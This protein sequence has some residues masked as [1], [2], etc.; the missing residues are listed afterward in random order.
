MTNE[1][2]RANDL[3]LAYLRETAPGQPVT[4]WERLSREEKKTWLSKASAEK[5]GGSKISSRRS[6]FTPASTDQRSKVRGRLCLAHGEECAGPIDPAHLV[7]RALGGDEDPR[8]VVPLCRFHHDAYDNN[9]L[10]LLEFLEPHW[11]TE[12]AYAVELVG[13]LSAINQI[14]G[15][16]YV[17]AK[18]GSR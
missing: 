16:R 13:L 5:V 4:Q 9:N 6:G 11:R 10:S 3:R 12:Q 14:T 15:E 18:E 7:D 2:R 8:A 1:D 17:P